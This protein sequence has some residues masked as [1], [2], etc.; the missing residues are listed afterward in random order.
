MYE[1]YAAAPHSTGAGKTLFWG[2]SPREPYLPAARRLVIF[3]SLELC[4]HA[5][6]FKAQLPRHYPPNVED[7]VLHLTLPSSSGDWAPLDLPPTPPSTLKRVTVIL[8]P[9]M[10]SISLEQTTTPTPFVAQPIGDH[11]IAPIIPGNPTNVYAEGL[12]GTDVTEAGSTPPLEPKFD[13]AATQAAVADLAAVLNRLGAPATLVG[14]ENLCNFVADRALHALA[15]AGVMFK[16]E[17]AMR[18]EIGKLEWAVCTQEAGF[19]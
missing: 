16:S 11:D 6:Y 12:A 19:L 7:I 17:S 9:P 1:Y 14:G 15:E 4:K 8:A 18:A 2:S 3:S 5:S 10:M 13:L